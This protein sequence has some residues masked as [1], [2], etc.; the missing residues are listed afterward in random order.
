MKF[1]NRKEEVVDIQLTQ[2]G[3]F[4]LSKGVFQPSYY[5]FFDDDVIYDSQYMSTGSSVQLEP[6]TKASDRIRDSI[7]PTVQHN[8]SGVETTFN[9]ISQ[10]KNVFDPFLSDVVQLELSLEE[11]LEVVSK[12]PATIENHYSM[13]LPMGTSEYNSDKAPAWDLFVHSGEISGSVLD[14]TGSSGLL[15]IPQIE[16]ELVYDTKIKQFKQNIAPQSTNEQNI[17]VFPDNTYIE[18]TKNHIL[19]DLR[20]HNSVFENENFDIEVYEIVDEP[21]N[22]KLKDTLEPLYFVN[23]I[24]VVNELFYSKDLSKKIDVNENNV[25][26]YFDI[27]VD[28]EISESVG[29]RKD[30]KT[31]IYETPT[32]DTEEPC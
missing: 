12:P 10:V 24:N 32:N 9:Q 11:K 16:M 2:Y 27:K 19:I 8:F 20:E 26:Y 28:D 21:V 30:V 17:T 18:V 15:K 7:R 14:Y 31:N 1:F 4:L 29:I 23:G 13:G 6:T 22:N 25:E 3:K 5:A